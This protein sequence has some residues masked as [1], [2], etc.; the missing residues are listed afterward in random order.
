MPTSKRRLLLTANWLFSFVNHGKTDFLQDYVDNPCGSQNG[1]YSIFQWKK[2]I[3][4]SFLRTN[5]R[6]EY[7]KAV[8]LE[9]EKAAEALSASPAKLAKVDVTIAKK[10]AKSY[11]FPEFPVIKFFKNGEVLEFI[12]G[13]YEKDIVAWVNK[14]SGPGFQIVTTTEELLSLQERHESFILGAFSSIESKAAIAFMALA[15]DSDHE[16]FYSIVGILTIALSSRTFFRKHLF[17]PIS[18]MHSALN[19]VT[20]YTNF[21]QKLCISPAVKYCSA[22]VRPSSAMCNVL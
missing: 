3:E 14:K 2:C 13:R 16:V 18:P 6:R 8:G 17:V 9:W 11:N 20:T 4:H 1:I 19:F 21:T 7:C 12:G 22:D 5:Y 15:A 10:L